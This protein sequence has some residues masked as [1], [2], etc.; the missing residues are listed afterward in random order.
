MKPITALMITTAGITLSACITQTPVRVVDN[1]D[2]FYGRDG[3][4]KGEVQVPRYSDSQRAVQS[5]EIASKYKTDTHRYG[6]DAEV[7]AVQSE[8]LPPL[9]VEAPQQVAVKDTMPAALPAEP[10]NKVEVA[11]EATASSQALAPLARISK[12]EEVFSK[13]P[14]QLAPLNERRSNFIWP[15]EGRLLSRFGKTSDGMKNDGI[16]IAAAE[17]E[18]IWAAA[19]GEVVYVGSDLEGY[20]NMVIVRHANDWMSSY[21]HASD[22]LVEKGRKVQQGDLLGYV[23]ASGDVGEP[24]L[25]FSM[26]SGQ[27][28]IDPQTLL[29]QTVANR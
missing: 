26:R 1:R 6:V 28:P 27:E 15:V 9:T 8:E 12:V 24:Q 11:Q 14:S 5:A 3:V 18:P 29:P 13:Q 23:G 25:H 16:N 20:G 17:G 22:V 21:A 10:E 19:A 4:Y 7:P 2:M